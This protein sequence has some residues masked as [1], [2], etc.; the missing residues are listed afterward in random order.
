MP[1]SARAS[2]S[3]LAIRKAWEGMSDSWC[4]QDATLELTRSMNATLKLW[5]CLAI[6]LLAM[7]LVI[8]LYGIGAKI[9]DTVLPISTEV[10]LVSFTELIV[11]L[12]LLQ[13]LLP[14]Y[15]AEE[16]AMF[17]VPQNM[18]DQTACKWA[19]S[20]FGLQEAEFRGN[21]RNH[22]ADDLRA[23]GVFLLPAGATV[24]WKWR[25]LRRR[26]REIRMEEQAALLL[27]A[28]RIWD[29]VGRLDEPGL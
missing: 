22:N 19:A 15:P 9:P 17:A 26:Q 28:F 5:E 13:I 18:T 12:Q 3:H 6:G 10:A 14:V 8:T 24:A 20:I 4:H 25:R 29:V 11:L 23:F 7:D 21:R 16:F 1:S 2:D 27:R